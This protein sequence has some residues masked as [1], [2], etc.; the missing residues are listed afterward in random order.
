MKLDNS[1]AYIA[2]LLGDNTRS[3]LVVAL[4]EGRALTAGELALR[5]NISPQTASN[6][7][8]QLMQAQLITC[9]QQGRYR[10]YKLASY[11][12]AQVIEL[13]GGLGGCDVN[14]KAQSAV[15]SSCHRRDFHFARSCYDHLAG[16][17]GVRL[18]EF[19]LHQHYL[20]QQDGAMIITS[21]G[22]QFFES[23][24]I[25]IDELKKQKRQFC[26]DC[27]DCTE[28][29]YHLAGALGAALLDYYLSKRLVIRSKQYPR[30]LLLTTQGKQWLAQQGVFA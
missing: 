5:A 4:M 27:L 24:G 13:L 12:V 9:E 2:G 11:R 8:H 26:R 17:L 25:N 15:K 22:H 10:Y 23:L 30:V 18:R 19:L 29:T 14:R 7:L 16:R 6:H 28:R 1:V 20:E 3:S 21:E